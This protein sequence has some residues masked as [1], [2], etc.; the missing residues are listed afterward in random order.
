MIDLKHKIAL[1]LAIL[2]LLSMTACGSQEPS[3]TTAP[4]ATDFL[5]SSGPSKPA[6]KEPPRL[7]VSLGAGDNFEALS[8]TYTWNYDMGN[9]QMS[10][11][12]ADSAHPLDLQEHLIPVEVTVSNV[13]LQFEVPPQSITVRCWNDT[14][15]GNPTAE[16]ETAVLSGNLLELKPGGYIYE[17][18]ATWSG[19]NLAAEGTVHYVF[20]VIKH[21]VMYAHTHT[22]AEESQTTEGEAQGY[23]GNTITK[24]LIDGKEYAFMGS[25]SIYL[26]DLLSRL[27]Y[28]PALLCKCRPDFYVETEFGMTYVISLS[29]YARCEAGQADLTEEQLERIR[30]ILNSQTEY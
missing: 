15:F 14:L 21:S 17:V 7:T 18:A 23:C 11:I 25:D 8:G 10:G 26:T 3:I 2:L 28:D 13:E 22:T 19:E 20:N 12:C 9:S 27:N 30:S 4:P 5:G 6:M 24:L 29:G 1:F 16:S